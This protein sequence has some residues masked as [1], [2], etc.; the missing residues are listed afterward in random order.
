MF[1]KRL[2]LGAAALVS[3]GAF[4]AEYRQFNVMAINDIYNIEGIDAGKSGSMARLRTLRQQLSKPDE[5]VLLLHAGDFLFP[6]SMSSQYKGA[7]MIDLM[8]GLDGDFNAFDGHFFVAIGNHEFD[9]GK[10]KDAPMLASRIEQSDFYWLGTNISFD[11]AATLPSEDYRQS[12]INNKVVELSGVKV[13]IF[14]ITTDIAIPAYATIDND[15][16]AV[17]K[18]NIAELKKQG[19]EVIFAVTHL[20]MGEDEALLKALGE[21]APDAIFGGHE[22]AR[23]FVCVEQRCI[24]KADADARSATVATVTVDKSGKV[25]IGF[26]FS[27]LDETTIASDAHVAKRTEDWVNRYQKEYCAKH[28]QSADCLRRVIGRTDV[29]LVAEELEIRRFETN[30]GAFVADQMFTAFEDVKLPGNRKIQ[31]GLL[32]SGSLRLNQN[33]PAG[34]E[35]NEWYLNGIFQYPVQL[36]VIEI[37]GRQLQQVVNHSISGW[38]GNGKYLQVAGLAFVHDVENEKALNLSLI[39]RNGK[40]TRVKDD[41]VIVAAVNS[42]IADPSFS[43]QDGYTMLNL[44][45]EIKYGELIE[46]KDV[47]REVIEGKWQKKQAIAPALPGRVCNTTRAHLPCVLD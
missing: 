30:L 23:Q 29:K 15:Y 38:T 36:R 17:S 47:V 31:V 6:S 12:V 27:I 7:Q 20:P 34:T 22:H 14:G 1:I 10:M 46:L 41:D 40:V 37:T 45:R 35:L 39:D 43:D 24:Y 21:E 9:K 5:D 4:S 18:R 19:A 44:E 16:V 32:N 2:L 3:A 13:G 33:I 26:R 8:N 25:D 11:K 42:Y 28:S